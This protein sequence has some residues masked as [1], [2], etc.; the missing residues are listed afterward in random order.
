MSR[1]PLLAPASL[2]TEGVSFRLIA[3][4]PGKTQY[5]NNKNAFSKK[6]CMHFNLILSVI[7]QTF[8]ESYMCEG[9]RIQQ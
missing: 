1:S 6:Q 9:P 2:E 5:G 4:V 8:T 7:Q 3:Q